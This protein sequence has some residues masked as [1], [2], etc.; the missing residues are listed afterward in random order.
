MKYVFVQKDLQS[1]LVG[2]DALLIIDGRLNN[3]RK[4][5]WAK[6]SNA[7]QFDK[8]VR[9]NA[10]YIAPFHSSQYC[11]LTGNYYYKSNLIKL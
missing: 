7:F 2:S 1:V 10:V 3:E 5:N 6:L 4:R 11:N 8:K 9:E